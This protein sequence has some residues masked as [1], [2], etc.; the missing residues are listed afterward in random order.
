[1]YKKSIYRIIIGVVLLLL[2][3][4]DGYAQRKIDK[5]Y[6]FELDITKSMCGY[7]DAPNILDK[8]VD[9][10][11]DA[12]ESIRDP[13]A[14]IVLSTFQD[15]IIDT[16]RGKD[17]IVSKLKEIKCDNLEITRTNTFVAWEDAANHLDKNKMNIVFVLTDGEHNSLVNSKQQ[18]LNEVSKWDN[19]EAE[20]YAFLVQLTELAI[21]SEVKNTVDK[22]ELVQII[23][24]IEFFVLQIEETS[25]IINIDGKLRFKFNLLK[26][27]WKDKYDN[28]KLKFVLDNP[29]F[30]LK[31]SEFIIAD[32]PIQLE[33]MLNDNLEKIKIALPIESSLAIDVLLDSKYPQI[34]LLDRRLDI[35]IRNKK[36][37]VLYLEVID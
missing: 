29:Y 21:D 24:G 12:I 30:K 23:D 36:E 10:M 3:S 28:L 4:V 16:W 35:R 19:H 37:K 22:T 27:N 8:V 31:Q 1:M 5:K 18:M 15:K 11:V 7:G 26:D 2:L 34:K 17:K 6:I 9:Q 32:L 33:I 14:E 13:N 25:P 20:A